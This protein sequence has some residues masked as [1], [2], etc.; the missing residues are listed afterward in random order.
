[1]KID[2]TDTRVRLAVAEIVRFKEEFEFIRN[3]STIETD[4][5]S[6]WLRKTKKPVLAVLVVQKPG[7]GPKLYRGTNMEVSM[8]TGSLCAERNVIGSALA[9]DLTLRRQDLK[10]IAVYSVGSLEDQTKRSRDRLMEDD[11]MGS[12]MGTRRGSC[13]SEGFISHASSSVDLSGADTLSIPSS[14]NQKH[15][16]I[17]SSGTDRL[18]SPY[19]H[20]KHISAESLENSPVTQPSRS[21]S[22]ILKCHSDG[23]LDH[24]I[25]NYNN[26]TSQIVQPA[27]KR[28][29]KSSADGVSLGEHINKAPSTSASSSSS[30]FQGGMSSSNYMH[31]AVNGDNI[32]PHYSDLSTTQKSTEIEALSSLEDTVPPLHLPSDKILPADVRRWVTAGKRSYSVDSGTFEHDDVDLEVPHTETGGYG[33]HG[34][35]IH[36][37][38]AQNQGTFRPNSIHPMAGMRVLEGSS[39]IEE[40]RLIRTVNM[41]TRSPVGK[42]RDIMSIPIVRP[43][44]DPVGPGPGPRTE[45]KSSSNKV[46]SEIQSASD[47][48]DGASAIQS[49]T[50][51]AS[52][53]SIF[54]TIVLYPWHDCIVC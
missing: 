25:N 20:S 40:D 34:S 9:D 3:D 15:S 41:L 17:S 44:G 32:D 4:L 2:Q 19:V 47:A 39:G 13:G 22:S 50:P 53:R 30:S 42:K 33:D 10:V 29:R 7:Q 54:Y 12:G 11:G 43:Q 16:R 5:S 36:Q 51:G 6:F 24:G 8:P 1:M 35:L 37:D 45:S 14:A 23:H 46:K 48:A 52:L 18:S 49:T 27:S 21:S 26:L 31:S 28:V 38:T